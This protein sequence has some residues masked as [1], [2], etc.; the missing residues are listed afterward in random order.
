MG[1]WGMMG[2]FSFPARQSFPLF[3]SF[4]WEQASQLAG[5]ENKLVLVMAGE[6]GEDV[7]KQI[8]EQPELVR[9]LNR[10]TVAI[11]MDMESVRGKAF[12]HR[13]LMYPWPAV[14]FFMPYADLLVSVPAEEIRKDPRGLQD[15][16]RTALERAEVKR[17]NSRTIFFRDGTLKEGLAEAEQQGRLVFLEIYRDSCQACLLMEK[18]V[19]N[20]D[21]VADFYNHHFISLK[22]S[23]THAI[24]GSEQPAWK[25]FPVYLFLNAAGKVLFRAEGLAEAE[26]FMQYGKS[27]VKKAEGIVFEKISLDEG[28]AEARRRGKFLFADYYVAGTAHR[29]LADSVFTA[30]EVTD[31][32][33][34]HFVSVAIGASRPVLVFLDASGRELHR[35]T[36]IADAASLLREGQRVLRGEGF[37]GMEEEY[38]AG[39][40]DSAFLT[41]YIEVA[42]RAGYP[43]EASGGALKYLS[44]FSPDKL[45]EAECWKW[46]KQYVLTPDSVCF[47]YVLA[48]K[49][50]F[51]RLFGEEEVKTKMAELWL[52]GA[53]CFVVGGL[54]DEQGFKVYTKRLK[55]EKVEEWQRIVRDAR[56][57]AAEKTGDWK[58]FV[59]LAEEKWNEEQVPDAELY[60]WGLKIERECRD[61]AIRYRTAR[62]FALAAMEIDKKERT[63]GKVKL[64]S[65]KGFFEKLAN[66]LL[67]D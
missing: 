18:N 23:A 30:P 9:E 36:G 64:N 3:T 7:E 24:G 15:A 58:T 31:F 4:T 57:H 22:E 32:F 33:T 8:L 25:D 38:R 5:R 28:L 67:E 29:R 14:V 55:K 44:A 59:I 2:S 20:L 45:E 41:D 50:R 27:A 60:Q 53:E 65:Y 17:K 11:K 61:E 39:R 52:A 47:E 12:Q 42:Y 1:F 62:W 51:Y 49:E 35:V 46:F 56:M 43:E 16:L 6:I 10:H 48:H 40:C 21:A 26:Q 13:L 63:S 34:T 54:F 19:F 37:V 66:D